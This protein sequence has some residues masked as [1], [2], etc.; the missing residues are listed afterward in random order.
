MSGR[1]IQGTI[2]VG[3][4]KV[5]YTLTRICLNSL[6]STTDYLFRSFVNLTTTQGVG[7]CAKTCGQHIFSL[8]L[9]QIY[10]KI[11]QFTL[12]KFQYE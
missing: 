10:Q 2:L 9:D 3:Y 1:V 11:S 5:G 6:V 7:L 8:D 12:S 4:P